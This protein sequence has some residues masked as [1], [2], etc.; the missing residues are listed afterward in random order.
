MGVATEEG[1]A[2]ES[3][4]SLMEAIARFGVYDSRTLLNQM[5]LF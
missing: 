4:N 2:G 5:E 3:S 1:S